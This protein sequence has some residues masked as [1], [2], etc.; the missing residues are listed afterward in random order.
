MCLYLSILSMSNEIT[1]IKLLFNPVTDTISL[2]CLQGQLGLGEDR[3]HVSTPR[4]LSY[5]QLAEVAQI[6]AGDSYSAAV[7]GELSIQPA[8]GAKRH[9]SFF[10]RLYN[11]AWKCCRHSSVF[12]SGVV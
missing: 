4:L 7:T 8:A 6:Q 12:L 10:P 2:F 1:G 5:S 9:V 3:I 11:L